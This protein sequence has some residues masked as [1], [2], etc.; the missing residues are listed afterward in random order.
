[1]KAGE[2]CCYLGKYFQEFDKVIAAIILLAIA[3]FVWS[4]WQHRVRVA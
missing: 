4:R 2:N 3:W 1:M